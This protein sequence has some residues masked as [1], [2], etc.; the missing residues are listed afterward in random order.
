MAAL[1]FNICIIARNKEKIEEKLKEIEKKFE[2]K[3]K[4]KA[5]VADFA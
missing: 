5:I 2:G 4:T 3:I 1:G